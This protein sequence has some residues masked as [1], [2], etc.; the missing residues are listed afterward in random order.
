MPIS[1]QLYNE[2]ERLTLLIEDNSASIE[3][4]ARYEFLLTNAGLP[5]EYIY[6]YLARAGFTNWNDLVQE[7][8]NKQKKQTKIEEVVIAGLIGLG[9]GV[10]FAALLEKNNK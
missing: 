7:R 10:L 8:R 4:Y 1:K 2:L 5:R 3:D 9:L 6:S